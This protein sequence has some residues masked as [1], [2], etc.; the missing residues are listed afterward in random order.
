MQ[1]SSLTGVTAVDA[2]GHH[3]LAL[4]SDGTAWAWGADFFGQLG[5]GST[6]GNAS[7]TP[8]QVSGLTGAIAIAGGDFHSLALAPAPPPVQ[9]VSVVSRKVHGSA[10]TFDVDLPL[11]GSSGIECR[12][13]GANGD[14]TLVFKF[15]NPFLFNSDVG[16]VSVTNGTG[17][18][19]SSNYDLNDLHNYI[20]NLTGVTNAQVVTI[21]LNNVHDDST[22]NFSS[23]VPASM[24]V[25]L[26]DTTADGFVNSGDSLQT[27]NRSGQVTDA[28][29]FRSDV[30]VDGFVNSGDAFIV[31]SRS[32][33]FLP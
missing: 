15:A 8:V 5:D 21:S 28:T 29:N 17:T 9:L 20:V 4:K 7:Y 2:G 22:G 6:T 11:T 32:G 16:G 24:G 26:G 3:C 27:R 23:A 10:G 31:R 13:G 14:Y 1:V 19:N 18:V 30:N 25:L 12:S 33:T